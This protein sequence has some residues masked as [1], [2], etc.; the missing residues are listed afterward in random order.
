MGWPAAVFGDELMASPPV[1]GLRPLSMLTGAVLADV[2]WT[3]TDDPTAYDA[4]AT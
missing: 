2:G 1:T 4:Y 3:V